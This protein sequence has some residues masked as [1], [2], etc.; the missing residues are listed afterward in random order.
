MVKVLLARI[1]LLVAMVWTAAT[2]NFIVPHL[3]ERNPIAERMAEIAGQGGGSLSGLQDMVRSYNER[4][5]LDRSLWEQYLLYIG[6][7]LK[8]DLGFSITNCPTRVADQIAFA[9]PWTIGL[10]GT[11]TVLA[12]LIGT[13]LG[14]LAAWPRAPKVFRA[15]MPAF[16]VLSAIPFYLVGLVLIY[17]LAF[18]F[19]IFPNGGG[20]DLGAQPAL[21]FGYVGDVLRHSILPAFSIVLASIGFWGLGMRGMM[22]T[23]QGEDYMVFADAKGLKPSH[24]F[25]GYGMRNAILPQVTTLALSVRADHQRFGAGRNRICLSGH[26]HAAVPGDQAVGLLHHLWLRDHPCA[27]DW[28]FHDPGRSAVSVAGSAGAGGAWLS[29]TDGPGCAISAATGHC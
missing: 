13:M 24:V 3:T 7:V 4:F 15:I 17:L 20:D 19:S 27:G 6:R 22:I 29:G 18:R 8:F 12:F 10:L 2:V 5:G 16:M 25:L 28:H 23:V 21:T 11:A 14:A 1:G 26:R 9:L